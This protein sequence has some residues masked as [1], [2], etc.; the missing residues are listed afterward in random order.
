MSKNTLM[1]SLGVF[2]AA[3][4]LTIAATAAGATPAK[5]KPP[6]QAKRP[7]AGPAAVIKHL[8]HAL[9]KSMKAGKA[10]GFKKRYALLEP[11]ISK[12]FDF[13]YIAFLVLAPKWT[14]LSPQ[15]KKT[16]IETLKRNIVATYAS[17]FN[18][19][20]G[21]TFKMGNTRQ[22]RQLKDVRTQFK[23]S[24]GKTHQFDYLMRQ[25][26]SDWKIV[27]VLADGVSDLSLKRSQ[28]TQVLQAK[29]FDGLID[30]IKGKTRKLNNGASS[31]S[32]ASPIP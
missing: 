15:Q 32:P 2:L 18:S 19:Y 23:G 7:S 27:N 25:S 31:S 22:Y 20:S 9:I 13:H 14:T 17:N 11:V 24:S 26:G 5:P 12:A 4:A 10:A 3:L 1:H 30:Y 29:G 21:E 16:F 8:D 6:T 28:Y